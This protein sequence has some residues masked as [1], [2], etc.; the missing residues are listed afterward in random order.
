M[1]GAPYTGWVTGRRAARSAGD[2][3]PIAVLFAALGK[4]APDDLPRRRLRDREGDAV[5][6]ILDV[7]EEIGPED[8][9][10]VGDLRTRKGRELEV[11]RQV[12]VWGGFTVFW[13]TEVQSRACA[14]DRLIQRK[15]IVP[16]RSKR[17]YPWC[18]WTIV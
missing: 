2:S 9:I 4:W 1:S 6:V 3:F 7:A 12:K 5:K 16:G 13:V 10:G 17:P 15:A 18:S 11:L 14:A 8:L